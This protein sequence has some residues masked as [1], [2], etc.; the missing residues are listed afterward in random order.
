MNVSYFYCCCYFS[1]WLTSPRECKVWCLRHH[2]APSFQVSSGETEAQRREGVPLNSLSSVVGKP[3]N[4]FQAFW[5]L[6]GM[7]GRKW[8]S[9]CSLTQR[10][11][12]SWSDSFMWNEDLAP[13]WTICRPYFISKWTER[14]GRSGMNSAQWGGGCIWGRWTFQS[15]DRQKVKSS[16][17]SG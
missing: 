1:Q 14:V 7:N 2:L 16:S 8:Q 11:H 6:P 12:Y 4:N 9:S 15:W 17:R 5:F 13:W 10:A 3:A